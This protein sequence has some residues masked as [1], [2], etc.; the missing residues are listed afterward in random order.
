MRF[1]IKDVANQFN[2]ILIEDVVSS[3]LIDV[4]QLLLVVNILEIQ[5]KSDYHKG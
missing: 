1:P 4:T 3:K 5:V 2:D